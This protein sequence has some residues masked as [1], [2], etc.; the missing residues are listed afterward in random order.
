MISGGPLR[1]GPV[2]KQTSR[3]PLDAPYPEEKVVMPYCVF[4]KG[5]K[6]PS[7]SVACALASTPR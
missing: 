7:L 5:A 3:S 1:A 6:R 4:L 2:Q